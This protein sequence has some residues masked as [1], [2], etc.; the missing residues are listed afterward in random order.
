MSILAVVA[1]AMGDGTITP[2]PPAPSFS[3]GLHVSSHTAG[4][5][6]G[7]SG[8]P[9]VHVA[10][11]ATI[12]LG[13]A[14]ANM[15][16]GYGIKIYKDGVLYATLTHTAT[17]DTY[18]VTGYTENPPGNGSNFTSAYVFRADVYD[19]VA[20]TVVATSTASTWAQDY[21]NCTAPV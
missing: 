13:W 10:T 14:L 19:L 2:P 20:G 8:N 4:T 12:V 6:S 1:M 5:C 18:T 7:T 21:G 3:T 15:T 17:T 16:S 9:G 11:S